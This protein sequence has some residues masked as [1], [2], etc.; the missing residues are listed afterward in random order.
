MFMLQKVKRAKNFFLSKV[1]R[2]VGLSRRWTN[3]QREEV[4]LTRNCRLAIEFI[5][6]QIVIVPSVVTS[7]CQPLYAF[8]SS[9]WAWIR[10]SESVRRTYSA[11][12]TSVTWYG[13]CVVDFVCGTAYQCMVSV[14]AVLVHCIFHGMAWH[15]SKSVQDSLHSHGVKKGN[16]RAFSKLLT[17][18][19]NSWEHTNNY[20]SIHVVLAPVVR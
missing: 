16:T 8:Q 7:L 3:K 12:G 11:L 5:G 6:A 13:S 19:G 10:P 15:F 1:C 2:T 4:G 9:D 17:C 20:Y 18:K 14:N